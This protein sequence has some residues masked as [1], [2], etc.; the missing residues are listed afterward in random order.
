[1][2]SQERKSKPNKKLKSLIGNPKCRVSTLTI[3]FF[4]YI[5]FEFDTHEQ[6]ENKVPS[7]QK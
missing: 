2:Q 5:G 1:M 3:G 4:L 7:Q 6:I